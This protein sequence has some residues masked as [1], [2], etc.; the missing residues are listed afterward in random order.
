MLRAFAE[1]RSHVLQCVRFC[2]RFAGSGK[3]V[4]RAELSNVQR[5]AHLASLP[6]MSSPSAS[7][8]QPAQMRNRLIGSS[9]SSSALHMSTAVEPEVIKAVEAIE[10]PTNK[11]SEKLL[12]IRHTTAHVMAMAVQKL[13]PETQ[14][15]ILTKNVACLFNARPFTFHVYFDDDAALLQCI[16]Q[17]VQVAC[18]M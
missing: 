4:S 5:R 6:A 1:R 12:K 16:Q 15:R 10:L 9:S 7:S 18:S 8:Q 13:F 11:N 17:H 2:T 14:V 3:L